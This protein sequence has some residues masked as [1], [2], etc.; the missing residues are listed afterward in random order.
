MTQKKRYAILLKPP[1]RLV[2]LELKINMEYDFKHL[3]C[4]QP[5]TN[6]EVSENG[7]IYS[8]CPSWLN[9]PLG[10]LQTDT[11]ESAWNSE[12]AQKIRESIHDG[13]F[14]FC[15]KS[16][17][18]RLNSDEMLRTKIKDS[19]I[20]RLMESH[21]IV[22]DKTVTKLNLCY[23]RSCNLQCPSCRLTMIFHRP[24]SDQWKKAK[25]IQEEIVKILH[26]VQWLKLTGSGD[27]FASP[28]FFELLKRIDS[29][30][31]PQLKIFLHTNGLLFTPTK[32]NEISS[33]QGSISK[34]EI[35]IDAATEYTYSKLRFPGDFKLLLKNLDFISSLYKEGSIQ[36][37]KLSFVVQEENFREIPEFVKLGKF[38]NVSRVYFSG[39][40]DWSTFWRKDYLNKAVHLEGHPLQKELIQILK[41]L[42]YQS[43][44]IDLGNLSGLIK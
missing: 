25:L 40:D 36:D 4:E 41:R 23:D 10:N 27:P 15:N 5:F 43:D 31:F 16:L 18:P 22:L 11:I 37:L 17:C 13:S 20:K 34:V 44:F 42:D 1:L 26:G 12:A 38:Y 32:W 29:K 7:E 2:T 14:R 33:A 39:L 8:C 6:L 30:L 24:G 28:L 35:S 19:Y 21:A 3:F 9:K